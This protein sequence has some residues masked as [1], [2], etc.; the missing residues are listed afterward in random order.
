MYISS[1]WEGGTYHS[2]VDMPDVAPLAVVIL[3]L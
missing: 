3:D 2:V 1:D